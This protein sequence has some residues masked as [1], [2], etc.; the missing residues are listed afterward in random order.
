[1]RDFVLGLRAQTVS[2]LVYIGNNLSEC[3]KPGVGQTRAFFHPVT[4]SKWLVR[5]INW[6]VSSIRLPV[7]V[8]LFS[9]A[10]M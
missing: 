8:Y 2:R 4:L 6:D 9:T 5:V 10:T 1:M 7:D 3:H